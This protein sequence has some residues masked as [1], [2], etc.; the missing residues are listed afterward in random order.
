MMNNSDDL[1]P[2][3]QQLYR[4]LPKE[5]PSSEVDEKILAAAG[6]G[7]KKHPSWYMPFSMAAS[8]VMVSSLV[9]YLAKQPQ[10]LEQAIAP[11]APHTRI[12]EQKMVEPINDAMMADTVLG[13][14]SSSDPQTERTMPSAKAKSSAL[15]AMD[16]K[17]VDKLEDLRS[18]PRQNSINNE[19]VVIKEEVANVASAPQPIIAKQDHL[20]SLES[21]S[22][23][24]IHQEVITDRVTQ[25]QRSLATTAQRSES[26]VAVAKM[27]AEKK[28]MVEHHAEKA[29]LAVMKPS[30]LTIEG[31]GLGMSS[32]QLQAQGFSCEINICSQ[33]LNQP[34]QA[35]YWG[36]ASQ[37]AQINAT[38]SNN[39][40]MML[41]L[42]QKTVN[43]D[44]VKEMFIQ[45]GVASQKRCANSKGE[46]VLSRLLETTTIQL[47]HVGDEV[48]LTLCQ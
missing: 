28:A 13:S 26:V 35:N 10:Q 37:H 12:T 27:P 4:Q 40:V 43:A 32:Q 16:D 1:D 23:S 44:I 34:Q 18:E 30:A 5:Q 15:M 38:L 41:S 17:A 7:I 25:E 11:S 33:T 39:I 42:T 20:E 6:V 36:V 47:S 9:L 29:K 22:L 14:G 45:N 46:W 19:S 21:D 3:L 24:S 31:I 8:V 48:V 2:R